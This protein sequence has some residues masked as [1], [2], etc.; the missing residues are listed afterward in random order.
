MV[1]VWIEKKCAIVDDKERK[2]LLLASNVVSST[3]IER[4][5]T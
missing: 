5:N 2:L 3:D 1:T 4:L